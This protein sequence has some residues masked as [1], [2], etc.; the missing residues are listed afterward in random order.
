M[1]VSIVADDTYAVFFQNTAMRAFGP[2]VSVPRHGRRANQKVAELVLKK[3]GGGS[4]FG[5]L[6]HND[7]DRVHELV[8]DATRELYPVVA[9]PVED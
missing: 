6:W 3:A 8:T 7:P 4:E 9:P 2:V 5:E 1:G